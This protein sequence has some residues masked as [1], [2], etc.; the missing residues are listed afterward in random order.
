MSTESDTIHELVNVLKSMRARLR[1]RKKYDEMFDSIE[2]G[3]VSESIDN[4]DRLIAVHREA[5]LPRRARS[6]VPRYARGRRQSSG[7]FCR[8]RQHSRRQR[9]QD[10]AGNQ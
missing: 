7:R 4:G 8:I 5:E 9:L 3:Q 6:P 2:Q 10:P 1:H